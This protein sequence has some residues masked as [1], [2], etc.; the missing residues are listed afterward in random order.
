[1]WKYLKLGGWVKEELVPQIRGAGSQYHLMP[2][3]RLVVARNNCDVTKL[4]AGPQRVHVLQ[5][6]VPV[7]RQPKTQLVHLE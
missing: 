6:C 7:A 3:K 1:M 5:G 4:L 2:F